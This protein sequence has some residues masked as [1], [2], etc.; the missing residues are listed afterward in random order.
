[1]ANNK[2]LVINVLSSDTYTDCH[3]KG[4]KNVPLDKLA[5]LAKNLDKK[6]PIVV[7]CASYECP[8]S[9]KAWELL[10]KLGFKNIWAYEGGMAEWVQMGFPAQGSC[11]ADYLSEQHEPEDQTGP[12]RVINAKE[13]YTKMHQAGLL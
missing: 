6:Q 4:S 7:Y 2:L 3:I 13:L 8:V 5:D 11:K 10:H 9:R 1:M 12:I